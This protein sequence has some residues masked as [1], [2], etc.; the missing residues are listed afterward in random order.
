M[1]LVLKIE[2]VS[3]YQS[4]GQ[5][6][7]SWVGKYR[8]GTSSWGHGSDIHWQNTW[9]NPIYAWAA[10]LLAWR[11]H[12]SAVEFVEGWTHLTL[13]KF[14]DITPGMSLASCLCG[15]KRSWGMSMARSVKKSPILS[16]V[17]YP[18]GTRWM[19]TG[20]EA[21]GRGTLRHSGDCCGMKT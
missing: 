18:K 19:E 5:K 12:M 15:E 10:Q 17:W 20:M 11:L 13:C 3:A 14:R 7:P 2:R 21:D 8:G 1:L 6:D 4:H 16:R 9:G